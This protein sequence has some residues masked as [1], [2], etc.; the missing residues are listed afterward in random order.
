MQYISLD[1]S[2]RLHKIFHATAAD[3]DFRCVFITERLLHRKIHNCEPIF[4]PAVLKKLT[5]DRSTIIIVSSITEIIDSNF[6]RNCKQQFE[7][8]D[9]DLSQMHFVVVSDPQKRMVQNIV[10]EFKVSVFNY[11]QHFTPYI[12]R[13]WK[14]Q[15]ADPIPQK[16]FLYLNR[17][18]SSDR[19]YIFYNLWRDSA[20]RNNT[21]ASMHRGI[22]WDRSVDPETH[23]QQCLLGLQSQPDFEKIKKFY[24]KTTL[25]V[26]QQHVDAYDHDFFGD[27]DNTLMSFYKNSSVSI[28]VES[29]PQHAA[30]AF[31][32]T[33]KLYRS[34]AAAQPF[35]VFGVQNYYQNLQAQGYQ[36]AEIPCYDSEPDLYVR[37]KMFAKYVKK[38]ANSST[39]EWNQY[40]AQ[41]QRYAQYNQD[42][43]KQRN[44]HNSRCRDLDPQL[45]QWLRTDLNR[46]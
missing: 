38:L 22:Y 12:V 1:P 28:V 3:S 14:F 21:H 18:C 10:P 44:Q 9:I 41:A 32:P 7:Q 11:W 13:S 15:T 8:L 25:P 4:D 31:M 37:A 45:Q 19:A 20:V 33:E 2:D 34:I 17:R 27:R 16:K 43:L 29:H 30:T 35:V 39:S 24:N 26:L 36:F 5:Q 42:I 46:V 23:F 40:L 6:V